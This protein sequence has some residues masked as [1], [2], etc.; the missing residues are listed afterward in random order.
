MNTFNR[1]AI[2]LIGMTSLVAAQPAKD[3]KAPAT[4]AKDAKAAPADPKAP[5]G[6]A[7]AAGGMDMSKPPQE[8]ADMAKMATG[9]WKCKGQGMDHTMKMAD[10]TATM[11]MKTELNGW[12]MHGSFDAKMGKEPFQFESYTTIDPNS[13][14]MHRVMVEVGGGFSTGDA[15]AMKDN[16]I[17]WALTTH[18]MMG[19]GMFKDHEDMSDMKTGAHMWGEMSM[20]KGKTWTKV[21]DMTCKK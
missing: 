2:A 13:K 7:P 11:K 17:E 3:A 5:A 20:D 9:T 16:K 21:Y 1:I 6:G 4:P 12:W 10:M 15:D 14:K 19:D 8:M 18:S